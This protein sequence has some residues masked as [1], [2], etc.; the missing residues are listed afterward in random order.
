MISHVQTKNTQDCSTEKHRPSM[1]SPNISMT[2][3]YQEDTSAPMCRILSDFFSP[4]LYWIFVQQTFHV[5]LLI[6]AQKRNWKQGLCLLWQS[7]S[8][9]YPIG[10]ML[11]S[12]STKQVERTSYLPNP[13]HAYSL[14]TSCWY[15][16]LH[17]IR[18]HNT[19]NPGS[20]L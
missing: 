12:I 13:V 17:V 9:L 14:V 8:L 2:L 3:D 4:H 5:N 16:C 19:L 7:L 6:H 20:L 15:V 11:G 18:L 1:C 10:I